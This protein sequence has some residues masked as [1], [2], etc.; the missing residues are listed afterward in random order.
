MIIMVIFNL[1]KLSSSQERFDVFFQFFM[2]TWL[3][4][5]SVLLRYYIL[6]LETEAYGNTV[7]INRNCF[8][9][10]LGKGIFCQSHC[11]SC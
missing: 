1:K 10:F 11:L 3:Y 2:K 9:F 8:N 4:V 5:F 7:T 6:P